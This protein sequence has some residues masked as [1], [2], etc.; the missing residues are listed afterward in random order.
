M[1]ITDWPNAVAHIDADAF[2]ASCER[3]RRPEL[4]EKPVCV[5]SNHEAMVIAKTYDAKRRGITTG[6]PVWEARKL[7]PEAEYLPADF[8]YYGLTARPC[9]TSSASEPHWNSRKRRRPSSAGCSAR[10]VWI[11]GMS[12][13][14]SPCFRWS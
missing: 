14:V 2:Y 6:M 10:P 1:L 13:A 8:G 5:L 11:F 9:S 12:C 7:L 4:A 3:V